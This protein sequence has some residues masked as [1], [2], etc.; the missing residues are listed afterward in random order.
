MG[1]L[2][3]PPPRDPGT[4]Y[5]SLLSSRIKVEGQSESQSWM[6]AG[7]SPAFNAA[8]FIIGV[9]SQ[10]LRNQ[11]KRAASCASV[12]RR[13]VR[14]LKLNASIPARR[15][16]AEGKASATRATAPPPAAST[17]LHSAKNWSASGRPRTLRADS[18][19]FR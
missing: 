8:Q 13:S 4:G 11:I 16:S 6:W 5:R 12:G 15:I 17:R 2:P 9:L 7:P 18:I 14:F 19:L 1:L 10:E 3:H